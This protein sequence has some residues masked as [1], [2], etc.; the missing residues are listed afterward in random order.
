MFQTTSPEKKEGLVRAEKEEEEEEEERPEQLEQLEQDPTRTS[1]NPIKH[2]LV[3]I[4]RNKLDC[5]P[6]VISL[7]RA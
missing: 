3:V 2:I 6:L 1:A 4:I 7:S 5:W